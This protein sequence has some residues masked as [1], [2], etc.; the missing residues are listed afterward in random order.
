MISR[1]VNSL[2]AA[3]ILL[4]CAPSGPAGTIFLDRDYTIDASHSYPGEK[5]RIVQGDSSQ[6]TVDLVPG[7]A[8]YRITAEDDSV[9]NLL[10]GSVGDR[11]LAKENA[12]L[13]ISTG[14][15]SVRIQGEGYSTLNLSGDAAVAT[16]ELDNH[17]T[18]YV[19]GGSADLVNA[20]DFAQVNLFDGVVT[21]KIV[22]HERSA[23][24]VA[25]GTVASIETHESSTLNVAGGVLG[26]LTTADSSTAAI[27]GGLF[28]GTILARERS[29][30]EVYGYG[31][32]L[33]GD[34]LSGWLQDGS[35]IKNPAYRK[36]KGRILLHNV[37]E[38]SPLALLVLSPAIGALCFAGRARMRHH[39]S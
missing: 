10:G 11:A 15:L 28:S 38:P 9:A 34:L 29:T 23:G 24:L 1:K 12:T 25:G 31:L 37:P 21:E 32:T 8:V 13:N 17:S 30:I 6:T 5:V 2:L 39:L 35:P 22:L 16:L 36:E 20:D 18:L 14:Q 33:A 19:T 27:S 7:G 4:V 26:S 3:A